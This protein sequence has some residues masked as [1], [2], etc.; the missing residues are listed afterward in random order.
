MVF[1]AY[2]AYLIH[3]WIFDNEKAI[4]FGAARSQATPLNSLMGFIVIGL[5]C[6]WYTVWGRFT[7]RPQPAIEAEREE[8]EQSDPGSPIPSGTSDA[9]ASGV[10]DSRGT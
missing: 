10:P 9:D 7:F 8:S 1:S 4:G 5:P 3:E 6:F 2:L